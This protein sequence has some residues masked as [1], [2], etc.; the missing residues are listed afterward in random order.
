MRVAIV[1]DRAEDR[2]ELLELLLRYCAES[3]LMMEYAGF[4]SAEALMDR[5]LPGQY[6]LLFLDIYM[7]KVTGMEAARQISR[8]DPA[9]RMIFSTTS[10][11]HAVESYEVHAAY[12][13]TKPLDY[14]RLCSAMDTACAELLRDSRCVRLHTSG[15]PVEVPLGRIF[16]VDCTAERTHLHLG[17][18][19]LTVDERVSAVFAALA[20]DDRFLNC[21]RNVFVNMDQIVK[22]QEG[23]F[24][25][26]NGQRV[27]IRQRER[28]AEKKKFLQ[29]TLRSLKKEDGS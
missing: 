27:P 25:L 14:A 18:R 10:H 6:D 15:V 29:Y 3:S 12:Y 16:F 28:N 9:C 21:N 8:M 13:L 17:D 23:D 2:A 24:Q 7:D 4:S 19:V 1:D 20:E 26:K 5:F 22:A 11:T